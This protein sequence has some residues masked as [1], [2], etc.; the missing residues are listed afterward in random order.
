MKQV[1]ISEA[2]ARFSALVEEA[3]AGEVIIITKNGKPLAKLTGLDPKP[4]PASAV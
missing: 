1:S 4:P 2:K 3:A